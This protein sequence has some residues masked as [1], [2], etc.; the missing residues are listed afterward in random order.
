M[1][2]CP[3]CGIRQRA[4]K[5]PVMGMHHNRDTEY[6]GSNMECRGGISR[7]HRSPDQRQPEQQT[8]DGIPWNAKMAC[9][10]SIS[11]SGSWWSGE[12]MC[13]RK[14]RERMLSGGCPH[15]Y[16]PS[17]HGVVWDS[18]RAESS[19]VLSCSTGYFITLSCYPLW[20]VLEPLPSHPL[21]VCGHSP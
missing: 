13:V 12:W 8:R 9:P 11:L 14:T 19:P 10:G 20:R 17:S 5:V 7:I 1:S 16:R 2:P 6:H 4:T 21:R 15:D 3:V 18:Q